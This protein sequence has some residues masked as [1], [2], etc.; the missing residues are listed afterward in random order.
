MNYG[1]QKYGNLQHA[2]CLEML[3]EGKHPVDPETMARSLQAIVLRQDQLEARLNSIAT[4]LAS[5]LRLSP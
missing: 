1:T 5:K 2:K 4:E 3:R